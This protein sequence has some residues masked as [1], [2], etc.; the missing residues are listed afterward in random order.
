MR[1]AAVFLSLLWLV[2]LPD[3]GAARPSPAPSDPLQAVLEQGKEFVFEKQ[4]DKEKSAKGKPMPVIKLLEGRE[5]EILR[6]LGVALCIFVLGWI[7]GGNYY[8]RRD[9]SKRSK[10]RL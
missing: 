1:H 9:R 3:S 6:W 10:I 2:S 8:L 4:V 5:G 7:C